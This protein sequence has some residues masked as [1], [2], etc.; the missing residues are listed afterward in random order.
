MLFNRAATRRFTAPRLDVTRRRRYRRRPL[1]Q[2]VP[3]Q[4]G[5]NSIALTQFTMGDVEAIGL[6][7]MDFLGLKNLAILQDA[8]DLTEKITKQPFNVAKIPLDDEKTIALF[9]RGDTAGI[10]QFES[11]GIRSVLRRLG[12]TSFEDIVAVNALYRPGPMDN[13]ESFIKRKKGQ[14]KITYPDESVKEILANTYGIIIYQEQVMQVANGG[15]LHGSSRY[16][17][18]GPSVK[19]KKA[20]IDEQRGIFCAGVSTKSPATR[21]RQVYET[22]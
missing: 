2:W 18:A 19:R 5:S 17:G 10:F 20:L 15:A 21:R 14:E 3:L 8:V 1:V 16:F 12:P 22:I 6:L 7:K 4:Q 11:N 9:A 13:I